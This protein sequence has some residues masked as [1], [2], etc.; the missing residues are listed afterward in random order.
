MTMVF[1]WLRWAIEQIR[2]WLPRPVSAPNGG[3]GIGGNVT[4]GRDF[5]GRDRIQQ[6]KGGEPDDTE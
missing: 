2:Q 6:T 1:A 3:V 4:V 5:V